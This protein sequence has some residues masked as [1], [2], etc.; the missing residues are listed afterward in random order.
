MGD[1]IVAAVLTGVSNARSE[2]LNRIAKL[3]AR[4]AYSFRN[5]ANQRRRVRTACT[6]GRSRAPAQAK[7]RSPLGGYQIRVNVGQPRYYG[8]SCRPASM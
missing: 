3:E 8:G 1:E 2:A 7:S 4:Q 5:P 6:R